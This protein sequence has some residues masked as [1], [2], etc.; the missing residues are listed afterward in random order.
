MLKII[1]VASNLIAI[2][3]QLPHQVVTKHRLTCS[4]YLRQGG[5]APPAQGVSVL[6]VS[7]RCVNLCP[8]IFFI[9]V[10]PLSRGYLEV[11]VWYHI[12]QTHSSLITLY[13]TITHPPA[14]LW[15][16]ILWYIGINTKMDSTVMWYDQQHKVGARTKIKLLG[17]G[18]FTH[19]RERDNKNPRCNTELVGDCH[20]WSNWL[21]PDL[22]WSES[23]LNLV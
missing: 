3:Y 15:K 4:T 14:E 5:K 12:V 13:A 17:R 16:A 22:D 21:R 6:S 9:F 2:C 18:G 10:P 20:Y 11:G 23:G 8:T 1:E 19:L 7:Q